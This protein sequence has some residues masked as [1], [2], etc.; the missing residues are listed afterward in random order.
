MATLAALQGE[1]ACTQTLEATRHEHARPCIS[2]IQLPTPRT[3]PQGDDG[4]L[5]YSGA[6]C[7]P[8]EPWYLVSASP[9]LAITRFKNGWLE[10]QAHVTETSGVLAAKSGGKKGAGEA[11]DLCLL[12]SVTWK[13]HS[14]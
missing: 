8:C 12:C 5:A 7:E 4:D 13:P 10:P 6:T 1:P 3:A 9:P 11:A 14:L 2:L